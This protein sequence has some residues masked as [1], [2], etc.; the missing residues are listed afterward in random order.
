MK[1]FKLY[2]QDFLTDPKMLSLSS[3]ERSCWITLLCYASVN[4]NGMITFLSEY[5]LMVSAGLEPTFE[6]WDRTIGVLEKFK[7]LEMIQLDNGMITILSCII[8]S[9][10]NFS[11]TP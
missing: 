8:S 4:D 2:G 9:F 6:E 5:Q 11:N 1:W 3:S 7:K 10:L